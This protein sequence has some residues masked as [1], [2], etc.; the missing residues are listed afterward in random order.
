MNTNPSRIHDI[1]HRP[2]RASRG[3][4]IVPSRQQGRVTKTATATSMD[5]VQKPKTTKQ[6]PIYAIVNQQT[7]VQGVP[8]K[9]AHHFHKPVQKVS[10]VDQ[11]AAKRRKDLHKRLAHTA[12]RAEVLRRAS[13]PAKVPPKRRRFSLKSFLTHQATLGCFIALILGV[14]GYVSI[15]T[16]LTNRKV[17]SQ[18]VSASSRATNTEGDKPQ[19]AEEGKD[20]APL[21]KNALANYRTAADIPRAVYINK[22]KVAARLL[23]MS[24]NKDSSLQAPINIY[25]AG[26]YTGS[27]K[28][29]TGGAVVIDGHASGPTREGLF[30]YLETLVEGDTITIETG[31][32]KKYNYRVVAK[33]TVDRTKVDMQ[34]LMLPHG[35]AIQGANFITCSGKWLQ[36]KETFSQRSIVY[37]ELI[38]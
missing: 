33:E 14:T 36:G 37:T 2:P 13:S 22:L 21:P 3:H 30:A 20:E 10:H 9:R 38:K 29:A 27:A 1:N 28:P 5:L 32:G 11:S 6:S 23:P 17:E 34:K 24:V 12:H 4:V 15:D 35:T 31:N 26:W 8:A 18:T 16:W 19:V 25:D 7:K